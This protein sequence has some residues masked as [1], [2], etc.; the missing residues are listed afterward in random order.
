MLLSS[1]LAFGLLTLFDTSRSLHLAPRSTLTDREDEYPLPNEGNL[2]IHDPNVLLYDHT[3]YAFKGAPSIQ[4]FQAP[5]MGGPWTL[6]GKV[7]DGPSIIDKK[8]QTRPWAPTA[9]ELNGTFYCF[10]A[11]SQVGSRNSSIGVATSHSLNPGSWTD[12]GALINTGGG[13]LSDVFPYTV[14]N[15]IDPSVIIAQDGKPWLA[16]GSFWTDI[17]QVPLTDNMLSVENPSAPAANHLTFIDLPG[18]NNDLTDLKGTRP[19]EGSWISY[20]TPYY[21]LWFS[22]GQCCYFDPKK[23]PPAGQEYASPVISV[24]SYCRI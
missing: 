11:I 20:R 21:Y 24:S 9:I 12:H 22:H 17:W 16:F 18:D 1:F 14:S 2:Q 13:D 7:L 19:E 5:S 4:Y 3:F 8:D 6:V 23:L 10:Y 15:A